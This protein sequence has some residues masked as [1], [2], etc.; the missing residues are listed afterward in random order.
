MARN[1]RCRLGKH[2]GAKDGATRSPTSVRPAEDSGQAARAAMG[3][4]RGPH[5]AR[6][7]LTARTRVE[8]GTPEGRPGS[9]GTADLRSALS[10]PAG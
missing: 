3:R 9:S 7:W 8:E 2:G 5:T 1:L 6:S 10:I 4:R